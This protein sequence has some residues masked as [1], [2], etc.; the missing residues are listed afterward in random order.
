MDLREVLVFELSKHFPRTSGTS[1]DEYLAQTDHGTSIVVAMFDE[2]P[3]IEKVLRDGQ[4][5][6]YL[7]GRSVASTMSGETRPREDQLVAVVSGWDGF[8]TFARIILLAAKVD[9]GNLII[10]STRDDGWRAAV[11]SASIV[12]CDTLTAEALN[13]LPGVRPF[14]IVSDESFAELA[15]LMT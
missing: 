10:R 6:V 1:L 4:R 3:K 14:P 7:K 9:P 15:A 2:K 8:L 12:V 5:C 11:A 13:G